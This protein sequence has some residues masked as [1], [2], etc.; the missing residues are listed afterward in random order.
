M[1]E[2]EYLRNCCIALAGDI[3]FDFFLTAAALRLS[4]SPKH[5]LRY[6]IPDLG[7]LKKIHTT[8][9]LLFAY[10]GN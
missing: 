4:I 6:C 8:Q 5:I 1:S 7:L 9:Y 2:R 10:T 3:L